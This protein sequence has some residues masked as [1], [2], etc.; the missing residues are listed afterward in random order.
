[1]RDPNEAEIDAFL[2]IEGIKGESLD[3]KFRDQIQIDTY[4]WGAYQ[5]D[6]SPGRK[7]RSASC[8]IENLVV[9]KRVDRA[10]PPILQAVCQNRNFERV[11]L[12]TRRAGGNLALNFLEIEL[13]DVVVASWSITASKNGGIPAEQI[14]FAFLKC[15]IRYRPQAGDG[16]AS[17]G[18][19]EF[20]YT[21]PTGI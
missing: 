10:T 20:G 2:E 19:V 18:P 12:F 15:Q 7:T 17:G 6:A 4:S 9:T 3:A 21:I 14:S 8:Q 13:T 1:M 5:R 16:K 11:S